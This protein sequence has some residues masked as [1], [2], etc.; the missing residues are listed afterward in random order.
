[1]ACQGRKEKGDLGKKRE[2]KEK[3]G[4]GRR[5]RLSKVEENPGRKEGRAER[6]EED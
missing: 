1:M 3:K 5:R 2:E 4:R 6:K